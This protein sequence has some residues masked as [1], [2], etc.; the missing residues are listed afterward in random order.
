MTENAARRWEVKALSVLWTGDANGQ[1]SRLITT[2][3][4][5]SLRWWCE[6]VVRGLGGTA[7]DPSAKNN[8]CESKKDT[9]R[10][11]VICELFGCGGHARK[12]RFD[13]LD[14]DG[15]PQQHAIKKDT[16]F[17]AAFIPL[18]PIREAEWAL[19]DL[20]LRVV[21]GYGA[22]GGKTVFKP[23]VE[24]GRKGRMHHKD[25][26][27]IEITSGPENPPS[28][29][30]EDMQAYFLDGRWRKVKHGGFAWA[31]LQNF[32][33]VNGNGRYLARQDNGTS[34]FN[35]VIGR[36]EPK[37][38]EPARTFGFCKPGEVNF[39]DVKKSLREAWP[40]L[41]DD[42]IKTGDA[43]LGELLGRTTQ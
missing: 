33:C 24:N 39:G 22:I 19:L 27:L 26:G 9:K 2:G 8:R 11:C 29:S 20:T 28:F 40:T 43:I 12:F 5:G 31:S 42:E 30:R 3:L 13:V 1:N 36:G 7:C 21:A 17:Q 35:R 6:V 34:S 15:K 10:R 4:L 37:T 25:F 23:S 41:Q 32:W 14:G 38:K 18:R 16:E